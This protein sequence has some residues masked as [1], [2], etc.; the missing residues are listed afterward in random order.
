MKVLGESHFRAS[1]VIDRDGLFDVSRWE[2]S[3]VVV[4]ESKIVA[5][6]W[7]RDQSD[8]WPFSKDLVALVSVELYIDKRG[9]R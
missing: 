6:A 9:D 7:Q 5:D 1:R 8:T 4:D 3:A 2:L